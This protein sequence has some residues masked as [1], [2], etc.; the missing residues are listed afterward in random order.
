MSYEAQNRDVHLTVAAVAAEASAV[1]SFVYLSAPASKE[2][3]PVCASVEYTCL[4]CGSVA[5]AAGTKRVF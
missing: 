5:A 2:V 4:R 3:H 1:N